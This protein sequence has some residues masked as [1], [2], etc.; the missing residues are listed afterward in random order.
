MPSSPNV[1]RLVRLLDRLVAIDTQNP[2]GREAEAAA[3]LA[4]DLDDAGFVPEIRPVAEGRANVVARFDNGEGSCFA[5]NSHLDTVPTGSGWTSDPFRLARRDGKLYGRG[6]C[7]AKGQVAAMVE[8][9]RM[10]LERRDIWR[11][12]LLLAFVADEEIDGSGAKALVAEPPRIDIVVVGE[13]TNNAVCAAHKGCL[14]PLIRVRG[15]AA[16]SSSPGLGRNAILDAGRLLSL[17]DERDRE[18]RTHRH[19]LVGAASL[20][21]TRIAGGV[22]DNIVPDHCEVV[23]DRR[24]LPGEALEDAL[25]ELRV[26]LAR[27]KQDHG[28]E[29]ELV[30]VRAMAAPAETDL[31]EPIVQAAVANARRHGVMLPQPV[32]FPASCDLVH[33]RGAG[34]KGVVLGPGSLSVAHQP[35]E[36]VPEDDLVRAALIYRDVALAMMQQ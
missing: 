35:D 32:G 2:P 20:T 13:P 17:L 19:P 21:V 24:L 34:S 23:L 25:I 5:L 31:D 36:Y 11:G 7:D 12:R 30:K 29:A 4:H 33:F 6:A 15:R 18:L 10:L 9:G 1:A 8:A 14:R 28:L 22:A 16:H 3:L 26:L 27:A